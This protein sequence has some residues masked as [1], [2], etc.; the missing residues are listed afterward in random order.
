MRFRKCE[1]ERAGCQLCSIRYIERNEELCNLGEHANN[2][3][4]NVTPKNH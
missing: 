2:M 1:S 3:H 4:M